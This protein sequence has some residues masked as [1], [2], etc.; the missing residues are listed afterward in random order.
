MK[1][2]RQFGLPIWSRWFRRWVL[3]KGSPL[4]LDPV[5][6]V[7]VLAPHQDDETLGCGGTIASL[8]SAGTPVRVI[9]ATDGAGSHEAR[10]IASKNLVSM[11]EAEA[12]SACSQLGVAKEECRFL[13]HPD[14]SL[15]NRIPDLSNTIA[16]EVLRTGAED[17]F[18]CSGFDAHPDHKALYQAARGAMR[19]AKFRLLQYPVWF[20]EYHCW[21]EGAPRFPFDARAVMRKQ[22]SML[23]ENDVLVSEVSAE[24]ATK[25]AALACHHSQ[26]GT[27]PG[28]ADWPKLNDDFLRAFFDGKEVFLVARDGNE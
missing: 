24:L 5:K 27:V 3:S 1:R 28:G 20:W 10:H 6:P 4:S 2:L 22:R 15:E 19:E 12:Y 13:R 18:V 23:M 8:R 14:G 9:F 7:I 17:V 26:M 11:R 25:R 21:C 16:E